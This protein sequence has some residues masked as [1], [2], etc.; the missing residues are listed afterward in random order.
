MNA[1]AFKRMHQRVAPEMSLADFWEQE[2]R[3]QSRRWIIVLLG[4]LFTLGAAVGMLSGCAKAQAMDD[5]G[6]VTSLDDAI[7]TCNRDAWVTIQ[8]RR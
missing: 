1:E 6:P 4:T 5:D 8:G 3:A 7:T 2:Q